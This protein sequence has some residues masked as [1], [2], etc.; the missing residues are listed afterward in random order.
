[1]VFKNLWDAEV[2]KTKVGFILLLHDVQNH[3]LPI[4]VAKSKH[5]PHRDWP[6]SLCCRL[7]RRNHS[8]G[9]QVR[10]AQQK[11]PRGTYLSS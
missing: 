8:V 2:G 4:P 11:L 3:T 9:S 10:T 7:N 5:S 6:D 1:M